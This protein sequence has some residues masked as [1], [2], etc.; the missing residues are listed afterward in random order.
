M[1]HDFWNVRRA[2]VIVR[3]KL[4]MCFDF[5]RKIGRQLSR[6]CCFQGLPLNLGLLVIRFLVCEILRS[7]VKKFP[8]ER[9]LPIRPTLSARALTVGQRQQH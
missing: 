6:H 3:H 2:E 4:E 8:H 5:L 1:V 9:F 7:G